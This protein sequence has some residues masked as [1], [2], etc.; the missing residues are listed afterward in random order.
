[1][2]MFSF[3]V[4]MAASM[5]KWVGNSRIYEIFDSITS[6]GNYPRTIFSKSFQTIISYIIPVAIIAFYP[7]SA[8]L[9]K[10]ISGIMPAVLVLALFLVLSI[11]FWRLMLSKYTSAGG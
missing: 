2:A 5:F 8:L 4:I 1:M 9:G 3:A 7:A 11:L 6:F 10:D